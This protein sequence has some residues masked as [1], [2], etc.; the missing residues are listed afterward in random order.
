MLGEG[1]ELYSILSVAYTKTEVSLEADNRLLP[2]LLQP[3]ISINYTD[4]HNF[5]GKHALWTP[6]EKNRL[7]ASFLPQPPTSQNQP[8][9]LKVIETPA[10][11]YYQPQG[12]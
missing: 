4:F 11:I 5:L 12:Q 2:R 6:V 8:L 1:Q 3:I 10:K 7:T 9:T